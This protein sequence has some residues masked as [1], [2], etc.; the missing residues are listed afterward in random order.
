VTGDKA[1]NV[2]PTVSMF[3][4]SDFKDEGRLEDRP[5]LRPNLDRHVLSLIEGGRSLA[6]PTNDVA[7]SI[8]A[9]L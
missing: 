4:P 7:A 8:S 9:A 5:L 6:R 3:Q 1:I 2:E